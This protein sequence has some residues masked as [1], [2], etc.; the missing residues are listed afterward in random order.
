[1]AAEPVSAIAQAIGQIFGTITSFVNTGAS[2]YAFQKGT[3]VEGVSISRQKSLATY[4]GVANMQQIVVIL[5]IVLIIV[6][7]L[8]KRNK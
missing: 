5:L 2:R 1:M 4:T 3:E 7:W 6:V 8:V